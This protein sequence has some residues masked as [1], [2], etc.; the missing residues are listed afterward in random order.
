[1]TT[2]SRESEAGPPE[3]GRVGGL[4]CDTCGRL[5]PVVSRVV[6]DSGYDRSNARP[7]YNCPECYERK[8][9]DREEGSRA[10]H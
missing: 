3:A 7:I 5:T 9:R 8:L 4:R 10:T 2:E 1:M 6:V